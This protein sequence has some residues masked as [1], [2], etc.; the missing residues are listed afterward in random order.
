[1]HG[2]VQGMPLFGAAGRLVV[3]LWVIGLWTLPAG[4]L[5]GQSNVRFQDQGLGIRVEAYLLPE[6]SSGPVSPAWSPDGRW[7]AFAMRG[8]IWRVPAGGGVAEALTR[9]PA[10][11]FEPAWSPDGRRLAVTVDTGEG[12]RIGLLPADGGE[13]ELVADS[14]SEAPVDI[15]PAW[16]PDGIHLYFA[17]SRDRTLNIYRLEVASGQVETA[18]QGPG[19][20]I[21]PA[22]SPDGRLLA[23]VAPVEGFPGS[24]GV[25]VRDLDTGESRLVFVEET[26]FRTWPRWTPDGSAFVL[27]T[28]RA[29][30]H[31]LATVS[32]QGGAP[33]RLTEDPNGE[34]YPAVSPV[35]DRIAFVSNRHGVHRLYTIPLGG[36]QAGGWSPVEIQERR[37]L[38]PTGLLRIR[39]EDG[40]S[41][42]GG[43]TTPARVHLTAADGR[44]YAPDNAFIRVA[45]RTETH[46]FHLPGE[47]EVEVPA[48]PVSLTA[49]KGM[50]Y[51]P[52][53][54][55]VVV[56]ASDT[57]E[58]TL[59]LERLVDPGGKGWVSGDTHGHDLHIGNLGLDH[60]RYALQLRGEDVG[61]MFPLIHMDGT[62]I[63][64]RWEDLTGEPHPLSTP[65][66][67]IQYS[68]E[69]RGPAGHVGL[70]GIREFVLP[71]SAGEAGTPYPT[72]VLN[73]SYLE[74]ALAQGGIGGFMHPYSGGA[75]RDPDDAAGSSIPVDVA[76]GL[77]EFYDIVGVWADSEP[78]EQ[79][80]HRFL[81]AGFRLAATGGTDSF[82]DVWRDP[83]VGAG[84]TYALTGGPPSVPD[85]LEAIRDGRTFGTNGPLLFVEV[86]GLPPG[87]VLELEDGPGSTPIDEVEVRVE[88]ATNVPLE[89]VEVVAGGEVVHATDAR[90]LG[91][92]F[93][94]RASIPLDGTTGAVP[95]DAGW[96]AVRARGPTHPWVADDYPYAHTTPVYLTRGGVQAVRPAD[97]RFLADV[98]QQLWERVDARDRWRSAEE[99]EAYRASVEEARRIYLEVAEGGR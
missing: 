98:V 38:D 67:V 88:V 40:A 33:I 73:S 65:R 79:M 68:Q 59:R 72:D 26:T 53:A 39:V 12:Y 13:V 50:E 66:N 10:Y 31:D 30:S 28:D 21:Q 71:L 83:P 34:L 64:G 55:E 54:G 86:E 17:S 61:V 99:C 60:Q 9:G 46:Y 84:R 85:F 47:G 58:V 87:S 3:G 42:G 45:S 90:E 23:Y 63:Q 95:D 25:W 35:G 74:A 18:A 16:S 6:L 52:R 57:T 93:Q 97:A 19:Q 27:V 41:A 32:V 8:D 69:F 36:G 43:E 56:T 20:W 91:S 15:Q 49:F 11:H 7:I 29:G 14:G 70:L 89:V 78:S 75:I 37:P 44:A 4:A 5:E 94:V 51:V 24:G 82:S 1:V 81:N 76:L 92:R 48:G 22:P 2:R 62:K 80:Y 77:G 96:I